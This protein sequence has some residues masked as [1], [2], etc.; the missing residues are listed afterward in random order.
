MEKDRTLQELLLGLLGIGCV[1][2]LG[3]LFLSDHLLKN[4]IGLWCGIF[5]GVF[6][7]LHMQRT[8]EDSLDLGEEYATRQVRKGYATR[9]LLTAVVLGLVL[10]Y[11]LCN[12]IALL[13][14]VLVLKPAIYLQPVMHKVLQ[15]INQ[16]G[17]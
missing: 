13:A 17:G 4:A 8:L 15:K 7:L 16:K 9:L 11:E 10:C 14:G 5:C 1:V 2:Q 12:P 6:C 3:L